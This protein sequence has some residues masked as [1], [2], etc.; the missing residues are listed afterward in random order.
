MR[1]RN[2]Q[3]TDIEA[4]AMLFTQIFSSQPWNEQWNTVFAIERLSHFYYS[5]GFI[6]VLAEQEGV[7]G[8]ALGNTEPF[9]FGSI[10]YL[11]EI[12]TQ[13]NLQNQGVGNRVL[14]FLEKE[15]LSEEV[16]RIYLTTERA[17]PAV[18]FYQ[19]NGFNYNDKMGVYA[20]RVN[21]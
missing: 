6:G 10:F 17:I 21:S 19:K 8:F 9:Y 18:N 4:C 14:E 2:I 13:T 3:E 7:V 20:K 12:C 15:L 1:L 11:R 5:K 16:Q